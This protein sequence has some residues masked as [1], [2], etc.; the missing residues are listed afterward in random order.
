[1]NIKSSIDLF[2]TLKMTSKTKTLNVRINYIREMI[3]S[4]IISLHF[5]PSECNVVDILTKPLPT[6]LFEI[7]QRVLLYGIIHG[8]SEDVLYILM[9]AEI[10][11]Y[12]EVFNK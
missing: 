10:L 12:V 7:H 5:I 1:M 3:N 8:L 4:G 2:T 6:D 11:S 9:N